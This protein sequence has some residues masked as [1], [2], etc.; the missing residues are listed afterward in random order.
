MPRAPKPKKKEPDVALVCGKTPDGEGVAVLRARRGRLEAGVVRPM[1]EGKS[2]HG[3]EVVSLTPRA[4][5]PA[6]CDVEV[7]ATLP[8][9]AP[10]PAGADS[11][12]SGRPAQVASDDYRRNYGRIFGAARKGEPPRLPN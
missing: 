3:G 4:D 8:A 12:S 7:H 9:S 2:L 11:P 5:A 6:V 1:R 10:E